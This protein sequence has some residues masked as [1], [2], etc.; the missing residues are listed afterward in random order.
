MKIKKTDPEVYTILKNEIKRQRNTLN[1][2]PSE[3]YTSSAVMETCATPLTNKYAEGYP[4]ARW[5]S[6]CEHIDEIEEL[7]VS[8][9]KILFGGEHVNVQ[10]HSGSQANQAVFYALLEAGDVVLGMGVSFGGHLTHG[11]LHNFSGKYYKAIPYSVHKETGLIDYDEIRYL[12]KKHHPRLIIAGASAYPRIID[13][14]KF[15]EI[16]DE[17]DA[18]LLADIAHIAGLVAAGCHPSPVPYC[19]VVTSTTHKTLRG[20]RGG[21][22][23]CKNNLSKKIDKAVFPGVQGGPFMHIIAAKAVCFKEATTPSFIKYQKQVVKNAQVLAKTLIKEG[24]NL[25]TGGTDNHLMLMDL[26]PKNISGQDASL[27]LEEVGVIVNKNIIPYDTQPPTVTSGIRPGTPAITTRGMKELEAK[28]IA[29][30]I[31]RVINFPPDKKT[32][33]KIKEEVATLCKIF[34][35]Y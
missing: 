15:K 4:H 35:T 9:A 21:F 23:I 5:Y 1:L 29:R 34:P 26:R 28:Q 11:M 30:I 10:P 20:P 22:I 17:V 33:R 32:H 13:F 31:S 6:G 14:K 12:A 27:L 19:D 25:L 3:N 7:A 18:Y 16:A 24:F 8:R 2:I